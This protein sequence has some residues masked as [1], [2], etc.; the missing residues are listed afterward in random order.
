[1][2]SGTAPPPSKG[3][4]I[5]GKSS[6]PS[7]QRLFGKG[8]QGPGALRTAGKPGT[9][10]AKRPV[11]SWNLDGKPGDPPI[12]VGQ[13]GTR[14]LWRPKG[15]SSANVEEGTNGHAG[16]GR[17]DTRDAGSNDY[18]RNRPE[19]RPS[20]W[21]PSERI[22][23]VKVEQQPWLGLSYGKLY[24]GSKEAMFIGEDEKD[25]GENYVRGKRYIHEPSGSTYTVEP[26]V[27]DGSIS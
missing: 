24:W 3:S 18:D 9:S 20:N 11:A 12:H 21:V 1:M 26:G 5:A 13:D 6:G 27:G 17:R 7:Q 15:W 19:G 10:T 4:G 14:R 22:G 2:G 8:G 25:P 16:K 23:G